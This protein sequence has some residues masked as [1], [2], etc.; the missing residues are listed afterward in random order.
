VRSDA[1]TFAPESLGDV[2]AADPGRKWPSAW[3]RHLTGHQTSG[4]ASL[5]SPFVAS[6]RTAEHFSRS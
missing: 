1:P 3:L 4:M 2:I 5:A 6:R